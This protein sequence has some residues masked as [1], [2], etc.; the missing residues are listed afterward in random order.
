M[1]IGEKIIAAIHEKNLALDEDNFPPMWATDAAD[2]LDA[3]VAAHVE[4]QVRLRLEEIKQSTLRGGWKK[5]SDHKFTRDQLPVWGW[6]PGR[7]PSVRLIDFMGNEMEAWMPAGSPIYPDPRSPIPMTHW[8]NF[9]HDASAEELDE[10][11]SFYKEY[12]KVFGI[13]LPN[14]RR[15]LDATPT[16]VLKSPPL[17][18]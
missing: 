2:Q 18:S 17:V 14:A 13:T 16:P 9:Y 8:Q 4:E 5:Y 6:Y 3:L 1:T 7:S 15:M 11:V 10:T 12:E